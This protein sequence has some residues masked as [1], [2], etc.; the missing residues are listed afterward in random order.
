MYYRMFGYVDLL[1]A[2]AH[3]TS[4]T[5][6]VMV[7]EPAGLLAIL[8]GVLAAIFWL[9]QHPTFGRPF[10]VI[11]AIVFCYFVPTLLTTLGVIPKES[12]LYSWVKAYVLPASLLLLIISLDLPAIVRLGGKAVIMLLAGTFSI[13]IGGPLALWASQYILPASWALP[14]DAWRGLAALSGS[15]IGGGANFVAIGQV[16]E[17]PPSMMALMVIPDV[18]VAN[19]W[20]G[21]LLYMSGKQ[22]AIDKRTGANAQ[23]IRDLE[24]RM[25]EFHERT[26]RIPTMTDLLTIVALG[27]V[28][29]WVAYCVGQYLP[30][31]HD[32]QGATTIS[33]STWKYIIV[34]SLGVGLSFTRVRNLEGAGASKVGSVMIY[35]LIACI[36]ASA[37][38]REIIEAP[39]F[40]VVGF[41]WIIVHI[42]VLL[43]VGILIRAPVFLMAVGSQAN[44]G[45]AASAPVVAAAF[46]PSLAPVGALLAVAGY[47][48][49]TYAGLVCMHLLKWVAGAG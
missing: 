7:D 10:K 16:A 34:T 27:F 9:V 3:P 23:A 13:V 18:L 43:T 24:V 35:L 32:G 1:L 41:I 21:V 44:I 28:G 4:H 2:Q 8:F 5:S 22:K 12:P 46:H 39:G 11:P 48:L 15:W 31:I 6:S 17:T 19:I 25:T 29:S 40:I 33:H 42:S 45:G 47:V 14:A 36:G 30:E 26:N 38:F 37:N 49:G 20:M